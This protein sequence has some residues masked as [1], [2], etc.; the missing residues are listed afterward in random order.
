MTVGRQPLS[1][2]PAAAEQATDHEESDQDDSHGN[3]KCT[4][5][6]LGGRWPGGGA[7]RRR[8]TEQPIH[9][10][11][12]GRAGGARHLGGDVRLPLHG[13]GRSVPDKAPTCSSEAWREGDRA[14][15]SR[16]A[17]RA[18]VHRRQ[19]DGWPDRVARRVAGLS[20]ACRAGLP[21][22]PASPA[23]KTRAAPRCASAGDSPNRCCSCRARATP[24]ARRTRSARCSEAPHATHSRESPAAITRSRSSGRG[25]P[26][27]D[28]V[29]AAHPGRRSAS[30]SGSQ[31]L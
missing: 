9:G 29:L 21:R 24:S 22:L 6:D 18:V 15:P 23:G 13:A 5:A 19:V 14:P 12:R 8:G 20:T 1:R 26:K 10:T 31:A 4:A 16:G 28:A 30:G 17:G 2:R 25:A 27:P 7:W 3:S 11:D